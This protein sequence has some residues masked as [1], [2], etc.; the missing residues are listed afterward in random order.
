[1]TQV[2]KDDVFKNP[3]KYFV[4]TDFRLGQCDSSD[5]KGIPNMSSPEMLEYMPL[6]WAK[7]YCQD[8]ADGVIFFDEMNLA[9][10]VVCGQAYQ[11]INDR[12]VSDLKIS[13][14]VWMFGAGNR[15]SDK[16]HVFS[17][18]FP[19]RDRF[20]EIEMNV[21][22]DEWCAW[23]I[24]NKINPHLIAFIKWKPDALYRP[25]DKSSDK[26]STPRG[27]GRAS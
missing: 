6:A 5:L 23:A 26:G 17:M 19:L 11:I 10:P 7:F 13:D 8:E 27:V 24:Q 1:M 20:S 2:I 21:N 18:P 25:C 9:P 22:D 12:V 3:Q 14:D 16:A 4:F 15:A